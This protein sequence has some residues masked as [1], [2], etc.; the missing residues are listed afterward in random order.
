VDASGGAY[1]MPITMRL[2]LLLSAFL[3][4][5]VGIG[6]PASAAVRPACAASAS[7]SVGVERKRAVAVHVASLEN[8]TLNRVNFGAVRPRAAPVPSVPLYLSRLRV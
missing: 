5:L 6:T 2:L 3:T 1:Y 8:G 4:A 7:A